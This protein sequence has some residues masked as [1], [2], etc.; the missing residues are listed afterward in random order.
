MGARLYMIKVYNKKLLIKTLGNDEMA[1]EAILVVSDCIVRILDIHHLNIQLSFSPKL[2]KANG[3]ANYKIGI[4]TFYTNKARTK[5]E[6]FIVR[7]YLNAIKKSSKITK[8]AVHKIIISTLLHEFKHVEDAE[9]D[10]TTPE[11]YADAMEQKMTDAF[12]KIYKW[13][14]DYNA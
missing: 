2:I 3:G 9:Y 13:Y 7:I 6:R 14:I 11:M 12:V 4:A 10:G 1:A 8:E 5:Y